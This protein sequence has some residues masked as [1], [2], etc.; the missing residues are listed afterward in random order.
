M[1]RKKISPALI[2]P[3]PR[4]FSQNPANPSKKNPFS[5]FPP[6]KAPGLPEEDLLA[7]ELNLILSK[8]TTLPPI[9]KKT[10]SPSFLNKTER[11]PTRQKVNPLVHDQMFMELNSSLSTCESWTEQTK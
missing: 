5:E 4:R 10:P 7:K 2:S 8:P 6:L 9:T 3:V 1:L 11:P